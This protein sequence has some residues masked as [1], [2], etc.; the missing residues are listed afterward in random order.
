MEGGW[1][2]V[3]DWVEEIEVNGDQSKQWAILQEELRQHKEQ[4]IRI[5]RKTNPSRD[6]FME[7]FFGPNAPLFRQFNDEA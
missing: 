5:L 2:D 3:S 4:C 1:K 6:D 7:Y